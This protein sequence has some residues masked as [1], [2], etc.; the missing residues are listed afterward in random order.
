MC[1]YFPLLT[2]GLLVALVPTRQHQ[3]H[4]LHPYH[5]DETPEGST[6]PL[7]EFSISLPH[8]SSH[9]ST[10]PALPNHRPPEGS[11]AP[12]GE[13]SI[14][15]PHGSSHSSTRPALPNHRPPEGSTAPLGEFSISLP[16]G[17]S[18]SSTRPA[19]LNHRPLLYLG[20]C[21]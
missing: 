18:H 16:H 7:G 17:S 15:L 19:L 3:S 8:G 10:R 4:R 13:F 9:S 2:V 14:S 1:V 20:A 5:R 21:Y 6:A 12:L 11:T